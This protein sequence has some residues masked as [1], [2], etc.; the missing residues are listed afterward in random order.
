[1][2]QILRI[3]DVCRATGLARTTIWRLERERCFPAHCKLGKRAIGWFASEVSEWL[4]SRKRAPVIEGGSRRDPAA[5]ERR[6]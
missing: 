2:E 4:E 3:R 6:A 5:L 1:M